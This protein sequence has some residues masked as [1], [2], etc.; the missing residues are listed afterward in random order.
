MGRLLNYYSAAPTTEASTAMSDNVLPDATE[1]EAPAD[2]TISLP[3]N[4]S[5]SQHHNQDIRHAGRVHV[6]GKIRRIWRPRYLELTAAGLVHYSEVTQDGVHV[7][8]KYTLAVKSARLLDSVVRDMHV[9]LPRG[10]IGFCLEAQR[11]ATNTDD[12]TATGTGDT[13]AEWR[14]VYCAVESLQDAQAWVVALQWA[15]TM[16]KRRIAGALTAAIDVDH[17]W[18]KVTPVTD[19]TDKSSAT[20]TSKST[21]ATPK[22]VVAKVVQYQIVR[23]GGM[24][25]D[26]AYE[27]HVLLLHHDKAEQWTVMRTANDLERLVGDLC[28]DLGLDSLSSQLG[29][30]RSLP[31][32]QHKP[33]SSEMIKAL[34]VADSI[35]RS[36]ILDAAMV[37]SKGMKSFLGLSVPMALNKPASIYLPALLSLLWYRHDGHAVSD[38]R[39]E[40]VTIP[41]DQYVKKWFAGH[42]TR[43]Q[44]SLSTMYLVRLAQQPVAVVGGVGA[45]VVAF[46]SLAVC[47]ERFTV[48]TMSIRLDILVVSW[49]SAAYIGHVWPT[50]TRTRLNQSVPL[51][52]TKE[53]AVSLPGRM[54][55]NTPTNVTTTDSLGSKP[56]STGTLDDVVMVDD[57]LDEFASTSSAQSEDDGDEVLEGTAQDE[58]H[59]DGRL[60]SPLPRFPDNDGMSCWSLAT[61]SIFQVRGES[62]FADRIKYP[63]GPSP[64]T[65]RGVDIFLTDSP[66]RH[67]ARHPAVLGGKLNEQDTFLVNFLLPFGNFVAYFSIPPLA[68]F[69]DKLKT[70]WTKFLKGDQEY[71]DARLKLLPVVVEGPWIVKTA[72]G[73]GNS[74]ALLGKVIP[75]QYFFREPSGQDKA[76]YEVDVIITASTVA[77]SILSVVKGSASSVSIAFAFIIEAAEQ[78]ELPETV[79]CS[80]QIHSICLDDCPLLPPF[81]DLEED[82]HSI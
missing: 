34:S 10:M 17:P 13:A 8:W 50:K 46:Q 12:T 62:Y 39:I 2:A 7:V 21:T 5:S 26:F 41:A 45:G 35:L 53:A 72:V 14:D 44:P 54:V 30:V 79:L 55:V 80:F 37:N 18:T 6:R 32:W 65:C 81:D 66:Q 64:L 15:A 60:S 68:S 49:L 42:A 28:Q 43:K 16:T 52:I 40:S 1:Q 47:W 73:P 74:P 4:T 58:T 57:E 9:G 22:I 67:I 70:V 51:V 24:Q 78:D 33:S 27:M 77:R 25:L 31:R 19:R 75:L 82:T 61:D 36:L 56:G 63:S 11:V 38:R 76:A 69:P 71:R 29:L 48:P 59:D 23:V 3:S 20:K